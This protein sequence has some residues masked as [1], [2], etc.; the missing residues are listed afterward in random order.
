MQ[1]GTRWLDP[2]HTAAIYFLDSCKTVS[3]LSAFFI[4][5]ISSLKLH[6][7]QRT[8]E[9]TV[10]GRRQ[11]GISPTQVRLGVHANID[12]ISQGPSTLQAILSC[13]VVQTSRTRLNPPDS[14]GVFTCLG[15]LDP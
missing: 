13:K 11:I 14:K 7:R 3:V 12:K 15:H 8:P 9:V 6:E 2:E 4:G 1:E 5:I 10:V